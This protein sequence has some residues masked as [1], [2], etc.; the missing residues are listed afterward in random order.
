MRMTVAAPAKINLF[1]DITGRR[2]DGYHLINTVMQTVSLFDDVTVTIDKSREDI[3]VSCTDD[4]IPCD[5]TNTAYAAAEE[6]FEYTEIPRVG[7]SVKIKKRIPSGAGM[8]GGSTDAAAVIFALNEM[9]E[10]D[11]GM[12]ELAEIGE[13]VGADVPFCIYG[14]TM[15]AGGIGTILSPLPDMPDCYIVI[16][17]PEFKVS[18]K[19]AYEKSDSVGY[20][21]CKSSE[22]LTNAVCNG[23]V[24]AI[25]DNLYNKFEEVVDIDEISDIKAL[26][27]KYG[28]AGEVM[29][30]SGSA[31]FGIFEDKSDADDC[32]QKLEEY[33][34]KVYLL[35]PVPHGPKQI[36]SGGIFGMFGEE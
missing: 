13:N 32:R 34:E 1:L 15:S 19:D 22:A 29:T 12:E 25:S 7:V 2:S 10:T 8:A 16:V 27:K 3:S 24:E 20:E 30:G 9:L 18:T 23:N 14:G 4:E 21:N 26:M 36:S 5:S 28:A 6:F 35:K 17:K 11:L 31:V 33:Y